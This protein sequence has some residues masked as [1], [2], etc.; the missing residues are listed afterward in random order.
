[1]QLPVGR[2]WADRV[3]RRLGNLYG[4]DLVCETR[5]FGTRGWWV[6]VSRPGEQSGL[7]FHPE[8]L[9]NGA[10]G[11]PDAALSRLNAWRDR[12]PWQPPHR[13]RRVVADVMTLGPEPGQATW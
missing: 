6:A 10:A 5:L 12:L 4:S 2:Q 1:M 11:V 3:V 13:S 7:L 9:D 8:Q